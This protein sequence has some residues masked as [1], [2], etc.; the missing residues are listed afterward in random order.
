[1]FKL[2]DKPDEVIRY[3]LLFLPGFVVVGL[4]THITDR[5]LS[6]FAFIYSSVAISIATYISTGW[7]LQ[8]LR[9]TPRLR[10]AILD[11]IS[12]LFVAIVALSTCIVTISVTA[13]ERD[14]ALGVL[15]MSVEKRSSR[16]LI[17]YYFSQDRRT[18]MAMLDERPTRL[19][20]MCAVDKQKCEGYDYNLYVRVKIDNL[21][22]EGRPYFYNMAAG[23]GGF[24]FSLSPACRIDESGGF[25][26]VSLVPGPALVVFNKKLDYLEFI[27]MCASSC[28]R[29]INPD[30]C[31][32]SVPV[33]P[34][35]ER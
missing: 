27:E 16:D 25:E 7:L 30:E 17:P 19:R 24:P 33:K 4:I 13:I 9:R 35:R 6:D 18:R 8:L 29:H 3:V 26:K 5:Q 20:A 11:S 21:H 34:D 15:P 1:M 10:G 32:S 31:K 22:F 23:S 28:Y 12:A 14:W 2:P